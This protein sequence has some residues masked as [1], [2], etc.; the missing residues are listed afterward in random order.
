MTVALRIW[1]EVNLDEATKAAAEDR[2]VVQESNTWWGMTPDEYRA[3]ADAAYGEVAEVIRKT[4]HAFWRRYGGNLDD[5]MADANT[6]F[7]MG[8][9][10][11]LQRSLPDPFHVQVRRW[12]WYGLFDEYRVRC[13]RHARCP[14]ERGADI[15]AHP[16]PYAA[17]TGAFCMAALCEGLSADGALCVRLVLEPPP[18]IAD[19]ATAKGGEA[20]NIR[21]TVRA[22]LLQEYGWQ[23]DRVNDAFSEVRE[24]LG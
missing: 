4:A 10:D 5:I 2:G 8:H 22:Y 12:V 18:A 16:D 3:N 15:T 20:R 13:R 6:A 9:R 17:D 7:M 24:A 21:S 14:Q 1:S 11:N 23:R 19:V